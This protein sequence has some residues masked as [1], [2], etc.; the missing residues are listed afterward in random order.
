MNITHLHHA[1]IALVLQIAIAILFG[2]WWAGAALGTGF[3]LGREHCQYELRKQRGEPSWDTDAIL[4]VLI[5][6]L[7][8]VAVA[9]IAIYFGWKF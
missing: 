3:Y 8:T 7:A 1:A 4:D 6:L 5:P 2:N 9:F